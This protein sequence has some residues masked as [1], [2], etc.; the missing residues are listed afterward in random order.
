MAA[1]RPARL[2]LS[3]VGHAPAARLP[4][5]ATLRRWVLLAL[6]GDARLTLVFVGA[7]A[8]RRMNRTFRGRDYATNV[9]TFTY[10]AAP[11][12]GPAIVADIVLCLPVIRREAGA[13]GKTLRAHLAHL[14]L[15]GVLHAQGYDHEKRRDAARMQARET[16]LLARLRIA[17]PYQVGVP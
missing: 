3:L 2:E 15:H 6:E 17:D 14:V 10:D 12:D 13:Q 1:T 16:A 8:G 5:R 4:T 11:A 9:L 7:R